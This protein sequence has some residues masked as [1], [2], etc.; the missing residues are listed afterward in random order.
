MWVSF[1]NVGFYLVLVVFLAQNVCLVY[2]CLFILILL[3]ILE[4]D[5]NQHAGI[6]SPARNTNWWGLR[7]CH[8]A[9]LCSMTCT[10]KSRNQQDQPICRKNIDLT[11]TVVL[12]LLWCAY[13][14]VVEAPDDW[15]SNVVHATRRYL[16]NWQSTPLW[17]TFCC[18]CCVFI[19]QQCIQY[20]CFRYLFFF[21][22]RN[23]FVPPFYNFR[24]QK[25][26]IA[27]NT[28]NKHKTIFDA[29]SAKL[30]CKYIMFLDG[31]VHNTNQTAVM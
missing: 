19:H 9:W 6:F 30:Q 24:C 5:K 22:N 12:T 17:R 15:E 18:C 8:H 10:Q 31:N 7:F 29:R 27:L 4:N 2:I 3:N 1:Q 28:K 20:D 14:C 16:M 21:Q 26:S 23:M 11:R 13:I 25:H